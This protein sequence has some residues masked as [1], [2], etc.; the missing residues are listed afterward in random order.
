MSLLR[1]D[2][3]VCG[4]PH[5]LERRAGSGFT[6]G[7]HITDDDAL[8]GKNGG[9]PRSVPYGRRFEPY[10]NN[11]GTVVAVSGKDYTLVASDTRYSLGYSVPARSVSRILKLTDKVVLASSGM[12]ADIVTLH[13]M[14]KLRLVQYRHAHKKD[15]SLTAASQMLSNMLYYRRFMPYYTFNVLGGIDENGKLPVINRERL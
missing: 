8:D 14:L 12:A 13:K 7:E 6:L 5:A 4:L 1:P 9:V 2:A 11:G 10:Q 15:M 3:N